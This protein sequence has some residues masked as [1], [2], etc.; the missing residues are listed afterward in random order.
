M[1]AWIDTLTAAGWTVVPAFGDAA[2]EQER[3]DQLRA[4]QEAAPAVDEV[5]AM[6]G[7]LRDAFAEQGDNVT[8]ERLGAAL[9]ASHSLQRLDAATTDAEAALA[10]AEQMPTVY[11]LSRDGS[12]LYVSDADQATIDALVA[13]A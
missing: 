6:L 12:S 9:L 3:L 13:A 2:P 8:R 7:R 1:S 10:A 5:D 4:V 11:H